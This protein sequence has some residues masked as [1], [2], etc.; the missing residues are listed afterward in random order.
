MSIRF[1]AYQD[2]GSRIQYS[3]HGGASQQKRAAHV[4]DG[5]MTQS[6]G[7]IGSMSG[8]REREHGSGIYRRALVHR[9]QLPGNP[10]GSLTRRDSRRAIAASRWCQ[11]RITASASS[12]EEPRRARMSSLD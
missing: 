6:F 10:S 7:G 3:S 11:A 12:V 1:T 2:Q 9:I 5:S 4:R 8:L